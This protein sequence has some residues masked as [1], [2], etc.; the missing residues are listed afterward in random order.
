MKDVFYSYKDID[1]YVDKW[2]KHIYDFYIKSEGM[3][4]IYVPSHIN[5]KDIILYIFKDYYLCKETPVIYTDYYFKQGN[6]K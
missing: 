6:N 5:I 4:K 3:E 2:D 1:V